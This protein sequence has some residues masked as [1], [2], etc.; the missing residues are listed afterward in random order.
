MHAPFSDHRVALLLVALLLPGLSPASPPDG[1][2]VGEQSQWLALLHFSVD[3]TVAGTQD[4]AF[5]LQSLDEDAAPSPWKEFRLAERAFFHSDDQEA[6]CRFP[7]RYEFL[8][9]NRRPEAAPVRQ[10]CDLPLP[11]DRI[12]LAFPAAFV[13]SAASMFGHLFLLFEKEGEPILL[14]PAVDFAATVPSEEAEG[15][16]YIWRGI[17]GHYDGQFVSEPFHRRVRQYSNLERRNIWIYEVSLS[18]EERDR[19]ALHYRE[20]DGIRFPYRF[21]SDNCGYRTMMLL[22]AARGS[23]TRRHLRMTTAPAEILTR[24]EEDSLLGDAQRVTASDGRLSRQWARMDRDERR[25]VRKYVL[26]NELP[27][28]AW[29]EA[30]PDA[31]AWLYEYYL[32]NHRREQSRD[33]FLAVLSRHVGRRPL[34]DEV[35]DE[36]SDPRQAQPYRAVGLQAW[37]MNDRQ[38]ARISLF[39]GYHRLE[40]RALGYNTGYGLGLLSLDVLVGDDGRVVLERAE[41]LHLRNLHSFGAVQQR[42]SFGLDVALFR[43]AAGD[44]RGRVAGRIHAF[45][46]PAIQDSGVTAGLFLAATL[47]IAGRQ[48]GDS[49]LSIGPRLDL[50]GQHRQ[51]SYRLSGG[52]ERP[53]DSAFEDR[54]FLEAGIYWYPGKRLGFN[55]EYRRER[56]QFPENVLTTGL[57]WHF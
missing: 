39:P 6:I 33:E 4:P 21:F 2:S 26:D 55:A 53:I 1:L 40:D 16:G 42:T 35:Q 57:R 13:G 32:D 5:Y 15:L 48:G 19:L 30:H 24:L 10:L 29:L 45:A 56:G 46:G 31:A 34:F 52:R 17:S 11:A 9:Q 22:D 38:A 54:Q 25:R 51:F 12:R 18:A 47:D 27:E 37:Q 50:I 7:A 44:A 49:L 14:A 8:R 28:D 36:L 41:L 20:V 3:G 43:R 23:E